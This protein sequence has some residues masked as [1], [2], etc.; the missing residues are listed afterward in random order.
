[1][2]A[3]SIQR[4][5]WLAV[6]MLVLIPGP[7]ACHTRKQ[8]PVAEKPKPIAPTCPN[9]PCV[10]PIGAQIHGT[11]FVDKNFNQVKDVGEECARNPGCSGVSIHLSGTDASGN[12]VSNT[13]TTDGEGRFSFQFLSPGTYRACEDIPIGWF[14]FITCTRTFT[15]EGGGILDLERSGFAF[16]N[17][18]DDPIPA[19]VAFDLPPLFRC[20]DDDL[21]NNETTA[22]ADP[23]WAANSI[24]IQC[25]SCR[26]VLERPSYH[27]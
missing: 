18:Q 5:A 23:E 9:P 11:A 8:K 19:T 27:S 21:M 13:A 20:N 7:Q 15:L 10:P 3:M 16:G 6:A 17:F 2:W 22:R 4:T 12:A 1:M 26:S 24:S 25:Q 14:S